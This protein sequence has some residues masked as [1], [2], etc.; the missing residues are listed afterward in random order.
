[1]PDPRHRSAPADPFIVRDGLL[2]RHLR[3]TPHRIRLA[4][5]SPNDHIAAPSNTTS[6]IKNCPTDAESAGNP[7][8]VGSHP[9]VENRKESVVRNISIAAALPKA[10]AL[11]DQ[12]RSPIRIAVQISK[13]PSP[14]E[15]LRIDKKSYTQ[16]MNGLFATRDDIPFASYKVNFIRPIHTSTSTRP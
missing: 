11:A 6:L 13:T 3:S 5:A 8:R 16:L 12:C 14:I 4:Q 7:P 15:K 1:M 9:G 2:N 10:D